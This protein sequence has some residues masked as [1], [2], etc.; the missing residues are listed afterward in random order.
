MADGDLLAAPVAALLGT[1]AHAAQVLVAPIDPAMA[2]TASLAGLPRGWDLLV[3]PAVVEAPEVVIGSGVR[4]SK[5]VL[6]GSLL[7]RLPGAHVVDGLG[8]G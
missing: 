8:R 2:D 3:D 5:L 6:P 7:A 1:W 4:H